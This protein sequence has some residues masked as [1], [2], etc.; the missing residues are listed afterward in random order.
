M[1]LPRRKLVP[2]RPSP[3]RTHP[4]TGQIVLIG[5]F[6]R[7]VPPFLRDV[8][9]FLAELVLGAGFRLQFSTG[10][11]PRDLDRAEGVL[12]TD[13][14]WLTPERESELREGRR[15]FVLLTTKRPGPNAVFLDA[16]GAWIEF[17]LSAERHRTTRIL[18]LETGTGEGM[19]PLTL[20]EPLRKTFSCKRQL[21]LF[22]ALPENIER[23]VTSLPP[24]LM[25]DDTCLLTDD[26]ETAVVCSLSAEKARKNS[27]RERNGGF[28]TVCM[29]PAGNAP[30]LRNNSFLIDPENTA[31]E[32]LHV[33]YRQM[34]TG[35][36][37][38]PGAIL[39][40]LWSGGNSF[41]GRPRLT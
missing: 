21:P 26:A 9:S 35:K 41:A 2:E 20:P 4:R 1:E 13:P 27:T 19:P 29:L 39:P 22:Q 25:T 16:S 33:L 3:R 6:A 14:S 5:S 12:I 10:E 24:D 40:V 31:R 30:A 7:G 23:P 32:M 8:H 11:D 18:F 38:D 34:A 15:G 37:A 17:L 36:T 28:W